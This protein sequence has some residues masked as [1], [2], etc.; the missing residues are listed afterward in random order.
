MLWFSEFQI[1][2]IRQK[3]IYL[4]GKV[5]EKEA[6]LFIMNKFQE[7][8]SYN[9]EKYIKVESEIAQINKEIEI[10]ESK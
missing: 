7:T 4:A 9:I 1:S 10:L 5:A 8:S 6:I 3:K 2:K